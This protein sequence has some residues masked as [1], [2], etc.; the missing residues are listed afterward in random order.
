MSSATRR[1][2]FNLFGIAFGLAGLAGVW[3]LMAHEHHAPIAVANVLLGLSTLA[4]L[5]VLA[6]YV[7][8]GLTDR[9]AFRRDLLDP[10]GSPFASL[11]L[12]TPMLLGA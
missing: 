9:A 8:Y 10:V 2:P 6:A 4:W 3:L 7:R 11:I 1:V 12:I 5:I